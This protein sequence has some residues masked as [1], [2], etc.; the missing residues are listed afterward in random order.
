AGTEAA[1][2]LLERQGGGD[3]QAVM[4]PIAHIRPDT[5]SPDVRA[6]AIAAFQDLIKPCV[7]QGRDGA[8]E[9]SAAGADGGEAQYCLITL[10][11]AEG[12]IVAVSAVVTRCMNVERARQRLMS[13]QLVAGYFELF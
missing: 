9:V 5:S 8:I 11:R 13:M 2:F 3:G 6:A 10:L 7:E 12:E 1:G 4:R